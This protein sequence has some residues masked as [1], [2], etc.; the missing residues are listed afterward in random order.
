MIKLDDFYSRSGGNSADILM[1]LGG[2]EALVMRL[3]SRFPD[4]G[5]FR[6][7]EDAL[8][9]GDREVSFRAAHT[10]KG[11]AANLG[12]ENI[13]EKASEI[14]EK[15]RDGD[16]TAARALMPDLKEAYEAVLAL[17]DESGTEE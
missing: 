15:L 16:V 2:N 17:L 9:K 8:E 1:R 4:D 3:L 7:L 13:R 10:L 14:T 12:L 5:S 11:V 6:S